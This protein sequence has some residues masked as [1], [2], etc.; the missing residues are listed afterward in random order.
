M[1]FDS[2]LASD[3]CIHPR[4]QVDARFH[5]IL[6]QGTSVTTACPLLSSEII[7]SACRRRA[8]LRVAFFHLTIPTSCFLTPK[9]CILSLHRRNY[10]SLGFIRG[11]RVH[12]RLTLSWWVA[13]AGPAACDRRWGTHNPSGLE[14][15]FQ[16]CVQEVAPGRSDP[17]K[18]FGIGGRP[19]LDDA[20][21]RGFKILCKG[22][23]NYPEH[24]SCFS[25]H[26]QA[27]PLLAFSLD[28][29]GSKSSSLEYSKL[30]QTIHQF[31]EASFTG[32]RELMRK[33][34]GVGGKALTAAMVFGRAGRSR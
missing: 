15:P 13:P 16:F 12:T 24:R 6:T 2:Q 25:C 34:E 31:T 27:L 23:E 1:R 18:N 8:D 7:I 14:H 21:D 20:I 4:R 26:H 32:K 22:V 3:A 10:A 17:K 29:V 9:G 33:G 19:R 5:P 30:A 11:K 28:A